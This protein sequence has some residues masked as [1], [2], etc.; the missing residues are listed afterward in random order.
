MLDQAT[1]DLRDQLVARFDETAALYTG[2]TPNDR[3]ARG[4]IDSA[5]VFAN[6]YA[7]ALDGL[8]ESEMYKRLPED[9]LDPALLI[10]MSAQL[11]TLNKLVRAL[12]DRGIAMKARES[13][14]SD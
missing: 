5:R 14:A 10:V 7:T 8:D 3:M 6:A 13:G 4:I 2:D 9:V 11:R 12:Y 1:H